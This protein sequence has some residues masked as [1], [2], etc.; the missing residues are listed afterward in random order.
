MTEKVRDAEVSGWI[1]FRSFT[2]MRSCLP[3]LLPAVL[4]AALCCSTLRSQSPE[5]YH[6]F[7]SSISL[8][9]DEIQT[10]KRGIPV[11]KLLDTEQ[12]AE[13]MV[14]G[15]IYLNVP[16]ESY[17]EHFRDIETLEDRENYII[18]QKIS[19]PP[20][21][22]DFERLSLDQQDIDDLKDCEVGDCELQL[23]KK[24][25]K[26]FQR[27]IDWDSPGAACQVNHLFR[28]RAFEALQRYRQGGNDA[29]GAYR[30]KEKPLEISNAFESLL[31]EFELFPVY[32]PRFHQYLLQYPKMNLEHAQDFFYWE[33]VKFGLKRT[34]RLNHVIIYDVPEK[35][36]SPVLIAVKQLYATHYFLTALDLSFC[37][38][39]PD[40]P[41]GEGFF[42]ITIKGSR[43]HGLTGFFG[44]IVRAKVT[45]DTRD[46][47][48]AALR[49]IKRKFETK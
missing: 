44:S 31:K 17:V 40:R 33:K 24:G 3:I 19:D 10:I 11:A 20:Q 25:I 18:V 36:L 41:Q 26:A 47:M 45:S 42:L 34:I 43:Q 39:D 46:A 35:N 15:A 2:L 8:S 22:S 38:K 48:E 4:A 5:P 13:I 23:L 21:I 27:R 14:F 37:V 1:S 9:E 49:T 32:L 7:R 28:K 6:F 30:D 16:I 12:D 29:L